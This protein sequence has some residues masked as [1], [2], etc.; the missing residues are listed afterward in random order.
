MGIR[1]RLKHLEKKAEQYR[2][3]L[4]L[5]DGT[6]LQLAPGERFEA[7]LAA[8]DGEEHWL[9]TAVRKQDKSNGLPPGF[10]GLLL[11]IDGG[12]RDNEP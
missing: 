5:P 10:C 2:D 3:E 8:M 6:V 4:V 12:G 1:R 7:F 9:L 11:A